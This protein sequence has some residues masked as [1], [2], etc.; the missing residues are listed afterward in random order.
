MKLVAQALDAFIAV[1][2]IERL[3]NSSHA[4]RLYL[5]A[6]DGPKDKGLKRLLELASTRQGRHEIL[7]ALNS[8]NSRTEGRGQRLQLIKSASA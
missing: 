7:E 6:V 2:L 3:H 8:G 1:G 4:A 5:L